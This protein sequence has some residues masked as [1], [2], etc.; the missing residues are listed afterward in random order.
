MHSVHNMQNS[1]D[2]T[3]FP[4]T[5]THQPTHT[6]SQKKWHPGTG[7]RVEGLKS[8]IHWGIILLPK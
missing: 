7:Y 2:L 6:P 1:F 8:E 5:P 3:P 4:P